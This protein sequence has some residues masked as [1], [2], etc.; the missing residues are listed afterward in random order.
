MQFDDLKHAQR[1]RLVFLDHCFTWRGMANRRDLID[2]FGIS[3]AQAALDFKLYLERAS[4][5]PPV[6]DQNKKTYFPSSGHKP[7]VQ[8]HLADALRVVLSDNKQE[9]IEQL[10]NLERH[11]DPLI[12]SKLY[13]ALRSGEA[14]KIAYISMTSGADSGQWI[15]PTRFAFDGERVH[16]RAYSFKHRDYRDYVPVRISR[17]SSFEIREIGELLPPDVDWNTLARI[18]LRPKTGLSPEQA[19]AVRREFNFQG[20][21]LCV[22]TRKALEYYVDRRWGLKLLG[23]R[24]ERVRTDYEAIAVPKY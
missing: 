7:M 21:Y 18:W 5:T 13:M 2:R 17:E 24:L 3:T 4:G 15:V 20:E 11:A 16:L 23:A 8:A 14:T 22:E 12:I 19:E 1:E 10:P 6:Y 9:R